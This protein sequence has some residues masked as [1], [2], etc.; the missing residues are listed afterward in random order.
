MSGMS[1]I[2][3]FV[4]VGVVVERGRGGRWRERGREREIGIDGNIGISGLGSNKT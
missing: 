4:V 2:V 1:A 3:G